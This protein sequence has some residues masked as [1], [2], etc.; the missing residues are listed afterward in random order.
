[1]ATSSAALRP[2]HSR[3]RK[4]GWYLLL[5]VLALIVLFPIYV[6]LVRAVSSPIA[7]AE[8]GYPLYPVQPQWGAFRK[9]FNLGGF[10]HAMTVSLVVTLLITGGQVVTSTMAAYAF[11]FL[12]FPFRRLAFALFMATLML[13]IEVTL[14]PN[15]RTVRDWGWFNSYQG[16]AAPFMAAALGTF[17]IR[18]GFMGVPSEL[19]DAARLDGFGHV[20]FLTRVA[21]PLARPVI[22]AFTV[23]SFL[24][25]WNQYLWPQSVTNQESWQT[26]QIRLA[27][28]GSANAQTLNLGVA[29]AVVVALPILVLLLIFQRQIVRGLTAGA[30]KG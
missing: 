11:A 25:A 15:L 21:V 4:A 14:I 18:Q 10:A 27:S 19:R 24:A 5:V 13:P 23:I 6:T 29:A 30:V 9:A 20:R 26:A 17:L 22:A 8:K 12:R 16:L 1:M 7:Y 2:A 28:F 3:V